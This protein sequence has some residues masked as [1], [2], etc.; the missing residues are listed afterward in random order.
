M[1]LIWR[2]VHKKSGVLHV[3][4]LLQIWNGRSGETP[5]QRIKRQ[6]LSSRA[7]L[8]YMSPASQLKCKT[9]AQYERTNNIRKLQKYEESE[10]ILDDDQ[11]NEMCQI[12]E[13]IG[14]DELAKLYKKG[15]SMVSEK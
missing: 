13:K 1:P 15:T 3:S 2:K 11:N 8:S 12:M 10:V 5:T 14:V 6:K 7:R 4:D 9:L